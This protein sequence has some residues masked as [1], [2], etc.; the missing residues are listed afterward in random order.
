MPNTKKKEMED[1]KK[2]AK[3]K[4]VERNEKRER[5]VQTVL[6]GGGLFIELPSTRNTIRAHKA[7]V[8]S[9]QALAGQ[10]RLFFFFFVPLLQKSSMACWLSSQLQGKSNAHHSRPTPMSLRRLLAAIVIVSSA[11]TTSSSLATCF[12]PMETLSDS[13]SH[14]P[15]S[16]LCIFPP[17]RLTAYQP[18]SS[19]DGHKTGE[20]PVFQWSPPAPEKLQGA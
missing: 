12:T 11:E 6:E 1:R 13:V 10:Q 8:A 18:V 19:N 5:S 15:P 3:E 4:L 16:S 9:P 14:L 20:D 17:G 2:V 7:K